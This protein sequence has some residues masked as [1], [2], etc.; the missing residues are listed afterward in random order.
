MGEAVGG[1]QYQK[2][3]LVAPVP[4]L[5]DNG[6]FDVTKKDTDKFVFRVPSLRNIAKTGPYFHDG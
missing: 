3:G 2:L 5:K 4:G 6:R 1:S